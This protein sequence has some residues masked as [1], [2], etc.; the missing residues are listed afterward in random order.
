M[1]L[2]NRTERQEAGL[3]FAE[4]LEHQAFVRGGIEIV[5]RAEL[6]DAMIH[7]GVRSIDEL[8]SEVLARIAADVDARYFAFGSVD[9]FEEEV[10]VEDLTFPEVEASLRIVDTRSGAVEAAAGMHRRGDDY[11]T[12]LQ[13]GCVWNLMSLADR[14]AGELIALVGG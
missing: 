6:R 10:Y 5:E 11:R 2:A 14:T 9:R 7:E 12:V 8:D 1:P 3:L 13:L 4:L